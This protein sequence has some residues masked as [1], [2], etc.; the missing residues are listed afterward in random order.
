M[1]T[2]VRAAIRAAR[3]AGRLKA[4]HEP[5]AEVAVIVARELDRA[6]K[7]TPRSTADI[8]RLAKLVQDALRDL[9]LEEVTGGDGDGQ[10]KPDPADPLAG[11]SPGL[12]GV[13]G[14]RA[15]VGDTAL[16]R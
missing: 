1:A 10:P 2:R 15:Q 12:A 11:D 5:T 13:L 16:A 4:W 6:A 8:A 7:A 9:P 14:A 3:D